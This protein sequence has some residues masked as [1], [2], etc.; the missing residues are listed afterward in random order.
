MVL[1][2]ALRYTHICNTTKLTEINI[3]RVNF[4]N[5]KLFYCFAYMYM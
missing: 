3:V 2:L 1:A 5:L 4:E